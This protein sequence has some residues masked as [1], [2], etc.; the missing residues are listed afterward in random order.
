VIDLGDIWPGS[1]EVKDEN[2]VLAAAGAVALTI[3][4]PD[5]S[6]VTPTITNPSTGVYTVSYPTTQ[7]G[8]HTVRWVATGLNASVFTDS[9]DVDASAPTGL[10]SLSDVKAHLNMSASVTTNDEELRRFIDAATDFVEGKI[11]PVVRRTISKTVIPGSDGRLYLN[12]PAVSLTTITAAYGSGGT[13]TVGDYYLDTTYGVV[14]PPYYGATFSL[15]VT[16]EYVGGRVI[17]PAAIRQA[18][19]DYIKWSWE[20]QRGAT[21]LPLPGGE[22]GV[23]TSATVPWKITQALEPYKMPGIG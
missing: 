21:A 10:V 3:T 13:Y 9:F 22:F 6:T 15:P 12:G 2:G 11:G 23:A 8:R 1:V 5:A 16:V 20:G 18:A 14:H 17:V 19:L 7:A 4:L